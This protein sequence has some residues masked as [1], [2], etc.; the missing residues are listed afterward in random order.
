MTARRFDSDV[1]R[2]E[3]RCRASCPALGAQS[4]CSDT[5]C[6]AYWLPRGPVHEWIPSKRTCTDSK[7][8]SDVQIEVREGWQQAHL[9]PAGADLGGGPNGGLPSRHRLDRLPPLLPPLLLAVEALVAA[10]RLLLLLLLLLLLMMIVLL[11]AAGN[12]VGRGGGERVR[13]GGGVRAGRS[14][15]GGGDVPPTRGVP[16]Q[17]RLRPRG[18]PCPQWARTAVRPAREPR[19]RAFPPPREPRACTPCLRPSARAPGRS[20]RI[21]T[22]DIDAEANVRLATA[23]RPEANQAGQKGHPVRICPPGVRGKRGGGGGGGGRPV[24]QCR[25]RSQWWHR[26][27]CSGMRCIGTLR[28]DRVPLNHGHIRWPEGTQRLLNLR[29]C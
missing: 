23:I 17:P 14:G 22:D 4:E 28:V 15:G 18:A 27:T 8:R 2:S 19:Q 13:G 16:R 21:E 12:G 25:R 5:R 26:D 29:T 1:M 11:V 10:H 3:K 6:D 20:R 7:P 9:Q 24:M